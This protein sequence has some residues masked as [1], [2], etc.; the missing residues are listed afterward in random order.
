MSLGVRERQRGSISLMGVIAMVVSFSAFYLVMEM[1]NKMIEDRNFT[2]Y[3]KSLA[4]IALRTELAITRAMVE[5]GTAKTSQDVVNDYLAQLG[6]TTGNGFRFKLTYGNMESTGNGSVDTFK[7]LPENA[8]SPKI[9]TS[10]GEVPP[11]FSAIKANDH[12][13]FTRSLNGAKC[14]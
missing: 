9:S 2:N 4:P 14:T 10:P 13:V 1:G 12:Y 3:A 6:L 5:Q 8:Q 7:P 11:V